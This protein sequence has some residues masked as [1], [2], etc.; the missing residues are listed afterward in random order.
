[1]RGKV[2]IVTGASS[3]IGRA[4]ALLFANKG[5][6]VIAVV[7]DGNTKISPGADYKLSEGDAVVLLGS[8]KKISRAMAIIQPE[9]SVGGFNA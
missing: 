9:S 2:V 1:M 3:G 7:R 4:A 5:A 8:A 6:T